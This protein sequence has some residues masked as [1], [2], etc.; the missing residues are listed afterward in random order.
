MPK[1]HRQELKKQAATTIEQAKKVI[2]SPPGAPAKMLELAKQLAGLNEIGYAR[3]VLLK[4]DL[5]GLAPYDLLRL[6]VQKHLGLFTY[7][8]QDLPMDARLTDADNILDDLLARIPEPPSTSSLR[9]LKQDTWGIRGA[10]HKVRW[11]S[12]GS[13]ESL[14]R[15]LDY[16]LAGYKMGLN[17]DAGAYTGLNAAFVLDAMVGHLASD[18]PAAI[19]RRTEAEQIRLAVIDLLKPLTSREDFKPDQWYY[20]KLAESYLGTGQYDLARN[21]S[22]FVAEAGLKNWELESLARQFSHL[23][24]LQTVKEG[25]KSDQIEASE[26]WSVVKMLLGN[27]ATAALSFFRGKVGLA[28]SGGGFRASLYHIGVLASLAE[29]D[30][31]RHVEVISCVSGGSILGMY[32]YLKVRKLLQEKPDDQI[33]VDDYIRLVREIECEFLDGVQKNLRMR[34]LFSPVSNL[35]VLFSRASSTTNR[36]GRL[37]ES[38]LYIKVLGPGPHYMD[39]LTIQPAEQ[40][41]F[42]P[43]YD[44][45]RRKAKVPIIVLNSTTLNTCH[46]WQFT[47]TFMGEPPQ[48][49]ADAQIDANHRLR[50]MYYTQAPAAYQRVRLGDAV[51]ASACVPG[52]FDPL[53][54]DRLYEQNYVVRLVDGGVFDNQGVATLH[55]QECQVML[56]SDASGQTGIELNPSGERLSVSSRA[57][58]VLMARIRQCQHQ[59]LCSLQDAKLLR[60]LMFVH[61]KKGLAGATVDWIGC[62]DKTSMPASSKL[63]TYQIRQ[64]VQ[65]ALASVRTDLDSFSDCEADA[66]MLSGYRA[67][68]EELPKSVTGF[69]LGSPAPNVTWRFMD[70]SDMACELNDDEPELKKLQK[71]LGVAHSLVFKAFQLLPGIDAVKVIGIVVALAMLIAGLILFWNTSGPIVKIAGILVGYFLLSMVAEALLVRTL[72]YRNSVLQ[73]LGSLLLVFFGGPFLWIHLNILDRYYIKWGPTHRQRTACPDQTI[74][75]PAVKI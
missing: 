62:S 27:N 70:I 11:I 12:Y 39:E 47:A 51:A 22:K 68:A 9:E 16:Y 54:L 55:E 28:L 75:V 50:R 38:Q 72:R 25:R 18:D 40:E 48:T 5:S 53:V 23:A 26:S 20:A 41:D 65:R 30:M 43:R 8:D 59:L 6:A 31:L 21:C 44:N 32:Y 57:N 67:T 61:L 4:A 71:A 35:S 29:R 46:N 58:N 13:R 10:V 36:L 14:L 66:L 1:Y 2:A 19:T 42:Y 49:L 17:P 60:G 52:L 24:R 74:A 15:S 56:V 33:T 64:D 37:Y 45:W 34:A 3:K 7:K 63:T 69:Q 73:W